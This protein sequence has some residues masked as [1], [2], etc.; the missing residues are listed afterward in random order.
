MQNNK[1]QSR[2]QVTRRLEEEE[3]GEGL[4]LERE[5]RKTR[6]GGR[7]S[8]EAERAEGQAEMKVRQETKPD[9]QDRLE[10]HRSC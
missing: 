1:D 4:C 6:E 9:T 7:E 10:E 2:R 8:A 3:E 5:G